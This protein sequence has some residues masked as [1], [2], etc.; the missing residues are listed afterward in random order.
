MFHKVPAGKTLNN[1][2][3]FDLQADDAEV[4]AERVS[5]KNASGGRLGDRR[6]LSCELVSLGN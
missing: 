3:H 6:E 4:E 5:A 1:R 2:L